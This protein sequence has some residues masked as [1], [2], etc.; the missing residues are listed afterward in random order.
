MRGMV[1]CQRW[2]RLHT[3]SGSL[4]ADQGQRAQDTVMV[5]VASGPRPLFLIK[6]QPEQY[7]KPKPAEL[8]PS[9]F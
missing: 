4:N 5:M 9:L 6:S 1:S 7:I 2:V 8:W 3:N